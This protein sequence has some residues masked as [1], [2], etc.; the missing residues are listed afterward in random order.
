MDAL[1]PLASSAVAA[2]G[3]TPS[4][5]GRL[6]APNQLKTFLASYNVQM[7]GIIKNV[8]IEVVR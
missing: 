2:A 5:P 1:I 6:Y 3:F 7:R 4:G 8:G